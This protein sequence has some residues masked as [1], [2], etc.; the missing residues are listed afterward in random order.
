MTGERLCR[1]C[2]FFK[3]RPHGT[4]H[5]LCFTARTDPEGVCPY[6]EFKRPVILD[7]YF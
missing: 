4:G 1:N 2:R 6:H 5:C 7:R 3:P